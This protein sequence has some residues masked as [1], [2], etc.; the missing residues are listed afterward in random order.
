MRLGTKGRYAVVAMVDIA[1]HGRQQPISLT[2]IAERQSLPL[3]Y[4]EQLFGRLR[5]AGLVSS[6]RGA[7]GGYILACPPE[8]IRVLDI[9]IAVD[10]PMRATRCEGEGGSGCSVKGIKCLT[11][12]LWDELGAVVQIFLRRITLADV[13]EKRVL[14]MGRYTLFE[15]QVKRAS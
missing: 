3:P 12:D 4:L 6:V 15:P 1:L 9:I 2:T 10:G 5:K 11:H 14:G 13:C 8:D 7:S